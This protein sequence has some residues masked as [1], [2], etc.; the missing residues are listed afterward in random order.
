ME[1]KHCEEDLLCG[2]FLGFEQIKK[3]LTQRFSKSFFRPFEQLLEKK[4]S[5]VPL[6]QE[7][8]KIFEPRFFSSPKLLKVVFSSFWATL[9]KKK[10][11]LSPDFFSLV[12][13]VPPIAEGTPEILHKV[14]WQHKSCKRYLY[15][16]NKK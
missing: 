10:N 9:K 3:K 11:F 2:H 16:F 12:F 15:P 4:S 6:L 7:R 13:T 5:L 14:Y 8:K 1:R